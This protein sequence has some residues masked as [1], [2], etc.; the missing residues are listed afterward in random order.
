M[1]ILA[2]GL[3][4][5]FLLGV[6]LMRVEFGYRLFKFLGDQITIFLGYAD[7]GSKL[8]FGKTYKEHF[9]AFSV[10]IF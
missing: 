3:L 5:Q 8:V 9:F 10:R 6:F 7:E 2:S 1:R 4:L